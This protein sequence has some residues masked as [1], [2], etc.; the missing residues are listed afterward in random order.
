MRGR[1]SVLTRLL[2]VSLLLAVLVPVAP[3]VA[4]P[5][6]DV[7]PG[8]PMHVDWGPNGYLA[9]SESYDVYWVQL[10][11]DQELTIPWR[12][13]LGLTASMVLLSPSAT[14]LTD[15]PLASSLSID[16]ADAVLRYKE[17]AGPGRY[18]V[19]VRRVSGSG[20]YADTDTTIS[21]DNDLGVSLYYGYKSAYMTPATPEHV[22]TIW[23]RRGTSFYGT[24]IDPVGAGDDFDIQIYTD[25]GTGSPNTLPK[26]GFGGSGDTM[27]FGVSALG[28]WSAS[29]FSPI[30]VHVTR[31]AG[32]GRYSFSWRTEPMPAYIERISGADRFEVAR[33][34]G[35]YTRWPF[36]SHVSDIVVASGDDAAMAD[37]L[38]AGGL[39]WAYNAPLLLV[40]KN[41]AKNS[42]T[43]IRIADIRGFSGRVRVHVVGGT[44]TIPPAVYEAIKAAA[45]G[46]A[47]IERIDGTNRYDVARK[48]ALRMRDVRG[49]H[50]A[51]VLFANGADPDKF[52]DALALSS[53]AAHNGMPILLVKKDSVPEETKDAL[54][55]MTL[56]SPRYLAGGTATVASGVATELGIT[57]RWAGADRYATAKEVADRACV[58]WLLHTDNIAIASKL[59]DALS[60]GANVG[61]LGGPVLVVKSD[62]LPASTRAFLEA[63]SDGCERLWPVGGP[64]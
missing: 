17:A 19:V 31:V 59:P 1:L 26:A 22:W 60:A 3:A 2:L 13:Q 55:A 18:Y 53:V 10:Q 15:P 62:A 54:S 24:L 43:L 52:F 27:S 36:G 46:A 58:K 30:Y 38:S 11:N 29:D 37:P 16:G 42:E 47:Y 14:L 20:N 28:L 33:E 9:S 6:D 7:L 48:I 49:G 23:A 64:L 25:D 45:G 34:L 51:G 44:T 35:N 56:T 4:A 61:F 63:H 41:P 8:V 57:E 32:S 50:A 39:C 12:G 5:N 40:S 21:T